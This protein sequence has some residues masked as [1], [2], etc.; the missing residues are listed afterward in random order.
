M[1]RRIG[2][3]LGLVA[4]LAGTALGG[5][6][7]GFRGPTGMGT[8]DEKDLPLKWDGKSGEGLYKAAKEGEVLCRKLATGEEVFAEKLEKVSRL[9]SPVAT[10]DGRVYFVSTGTS[11]VL[12]AGCGRARARGRGDRIAP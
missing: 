7:P 8:I 3:A 9:A 2:W 12:R 6:W 5:N 4:V 11:H 10:A 1:T